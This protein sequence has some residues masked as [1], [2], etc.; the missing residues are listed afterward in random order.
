LNKYWPKQWKKALPNFLGDDFFSS[1]ENMENMEMEST[2]DNETG[3]QKN[4]PSS[5]KVN[6]YESGNVLLCVFRLPGLK[7]K[8]VDFDIYDKTLEIT[9]AVHLEPD[10]FRPIHLEIFQ[11][12]V[13]RKV[14]LPYRVRSDKVEASYKHGYLFV[15]LHR[16]IRSNYEKPNVTIDDLD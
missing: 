7:L 12:A 10:G 9:G 4:H 11:G 1:F 15:Y 8:E 16:L 14:T 5:I 3:N 6:L 2:T 13:K